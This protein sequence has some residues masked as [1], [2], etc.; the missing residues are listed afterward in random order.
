M[1]EERDS[2][3][4]TV[5]KLFFLLT[6]F[7]KYGRILKV[8][9]TIKDEWKTCISYIFESVCVYVHAQ[10]EHMHSVSCTML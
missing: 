6:P 9:P 10:G 1:S 5:V 4:L 8:V 2:D 3:T 7:I